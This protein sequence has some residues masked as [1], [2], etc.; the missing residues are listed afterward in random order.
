GV[1]IGSSGV[2]RHLQFP[3]NR[4]GHLCPAVTFFRVS[5]AVSV[6]CITN[7]VSHFANSLVKKVVFTQPRITS[8][9]TCVNLAGSFPK[10]D[11]SGTCQIGRYGAARSSLAAMMGLRYLALA[12]VW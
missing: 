6:M 7:G 2:V 10:R 11:L 3:P 9:N 1:A 8:S 5:N 4:L 12:L